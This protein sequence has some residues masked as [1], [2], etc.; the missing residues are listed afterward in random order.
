MGSN[1][2]RASV[3]VDA[4]VRGYAAGMKTADDLQRRWIGSLDGAQAELEAANTGANKLTE[5]MRRLALEQ[6]KASAAA[7]KSGLAGEADKAALALGKGSEAAKSLAAQRLAEAD[8]IAQ[9]VRVLKALGAQQ[10]QID[11]AV[12]TEVALRKRAAELVGNTAKVAE[13]AMRQEVAAAAGLAQAAAE[14]AARQSKATRE[15][16]QL[17]VQYLKTEA[18]LIRAKAVTQSTSDKAHTQ[19]IR[20]ALGLE[21][22]ALELERSQTASKHEQL[23]IEEQLAKNARAQSDNDNDEQKRA[24]E[25]QRNS[26]GEGQGGDPT[27]KSRE[28]AKA[29]AHWFDRAKGSVGGFLDTLGGIGLASIGL[30]ALPDLISKV[31]SAL[32][33]MADKTIAA[34]RATFSLQLNIAGARAALGGQIDDLKLAQMANKA[35]A[36]G[37]AK[38]GAELTLIAAGVRVIAAKLGEDTEQLFDNAITAIGRRS[39]MILDNLGILLN[40]TKAEKLYAKSIGTTVEKLSDE[41]KQLAFSREA[42]RAIGAAA[43]DAAKSNAAAAAAYKQLKVDMTNVALGAVGFTDKI[44]KVREGMRSMTE[45]ELRWLEN[46]KKQGGAIT[47]LNRALTEKASIQQAEIEAVTGL[48]VPL[49]DLKISYEDIKAAADDLGVSVQTLIDRQREQSEID[50]GVADAERRSKEK[51]DNAKE[52]AKWSDENADSTEHMVELQRIMGVSEADLVEQIELGL[53]YRM[54]SAEFAKDEAA[55]L[56]YTRQ[57][58]LL[59]AREAAGEFKKKSGGG[60][61]N[62]AAELLKLEQ[63]RASEAIEFRLEMA[64]ADADEARSLQ[65]RRYDTLAIVELERQQLDM[66]RQIA[67]AMP[68]KTK[69]Q[70]AEKAIELAQLEFDVE[71]QRREEANRASGFE[72]EAM[73]ER[74]AMLD[75]EIER[76]SALGVSVALLAQQRADLELTQIQRFGTLEEQSQLQHERDLAS[77]EEAKTR[78]VDKREAEA[79]AFQ[80]HVEILDAQGIETANLADQQIQNEIRVAKAEGDHDKVRQLLHQQEVGRI[81]REIEQRRKSLDATSSFLNIGSQLAGEVINASIKDDAK[82]ERASLRLKGVMAIA[83]AAFE[84]V[85][86]AASFARYDFVGGALHV[87]AATLGYVQGGIMLAGGIPSKGGGKAGGGA[88]AGG[89]GFGEDQFGSSSLKDKPAAPLSSD[90]LDDARGTSPRKSKPTG[91]GGGGTVININGPLVTADS[92]YLLSQVDKKKAA[93]WGN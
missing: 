58:E 68:E 53:K 10:W 4:D 82:R 29:T 79:L 26:R 87:A 8:A 24:R 57:I 73:V 15:H 37:V 40:Q 84:T 20:E 59:R 72:R 51:A 52:R 5:S 31:D 69:I 61:R 7:G 56:D 77:I 60:G 14:P 11:E 30:Q 41:Q 6:A 19:A 2:H 48:V 92:S 90:E 63:Q 78:L 36:L 9:Q 74:M 80:Q 65:A 43:K 32:T 18:E 12:Q 75:R 17:A 25:R 34:D 23:K 55:V 22:Q 33:S 67:N 44:G 50:K 54:A 28:G 91:N 71:R 3:E 21:R 13:L 27:E 46:S 16:G 45:Q 85:E 81:K 76:N 49:N 62:I 70:Q 35:Y 39:A 83:T 38:T 47:T 1:S 64:K 93:S 66:R 42:M 89:G 88:S 86:A